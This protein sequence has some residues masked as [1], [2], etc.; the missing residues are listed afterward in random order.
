M[1]SY[2]SLNNMKEFN[3]VFREFLDQKGNLLKSKL[4]KDGSVNKKCNL[5]NVSFTSIIRNS[6]REMDFIFIPKQDLC[7]LKRYIYI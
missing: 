7:F 4:D 3:K 2:K 5:N 6:N 1:Y